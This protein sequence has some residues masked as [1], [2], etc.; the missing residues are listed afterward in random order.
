MNPPGPFNP[1]PRLLLGPGPCDAHP[2]VLRA[3]AAPLLGHLDPYFLGIMAETQ[4]MLR[5]AFQTAKIGRAHV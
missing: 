3:M 5:A 2:R 4:E 1:P